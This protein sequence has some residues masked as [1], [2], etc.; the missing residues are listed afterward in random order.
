MRVYSKWINMDFN[1]EGSGLVE[2][3]FYKDVIPWLEII[4]DREKAL[5][6]DDSTVMTIESR[7]AYMIDF[8]M[9]FQL[10]IEVYPAIEPLPPH[11]V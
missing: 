3:K 2:M 10:V 4:E 6:F 5:G 8:R 9:V 7:A 1:Q 11:S